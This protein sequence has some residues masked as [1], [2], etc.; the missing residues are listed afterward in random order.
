VGGPNLG[1]SPQA[2]VCSSE[3]GG[4]L[5]TSKTGS[6]RRPLSAN[7]RRDSHQG[8]E[9]IKKMVRTHPPETPLT[10]QAQDFRGRESPG[11]TPNTAPAAVSPLEAARR[12]PT[13]WRRGCGGVPVRAATRDQQR[14]PLIEPTRHPLAV[15]EPSARP[16]TRWPA[17]SRLGGA[18]L[19]HRAR[20]S[21]GHR[22][23]GSDA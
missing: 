6:A 3:P 19:H 10:A 21:V 15:I 18:D 1:A 5:P 2:T 20:L 23:H 7:S 16:P 22:E 12:T 4:S 11:K 14:K 13:A 8:V 9:Q 17:G